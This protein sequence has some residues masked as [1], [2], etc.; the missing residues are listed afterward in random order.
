VGSESI[1]KITFFGL[2]PQKAYRKLQ[3][4]HLMLRLNNGAGWI[5]PAPSSDLSLEEKSSCA[6]LFWGEVAF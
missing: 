2:T 3:E 4:W 1:R 6:G 5:P